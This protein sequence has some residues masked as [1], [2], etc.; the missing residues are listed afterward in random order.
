MNI[1]HS[2]SFFTLFSTFYNSSLAQIYIYN[3]PKILHST[4]FLG[5][6]ST[7]YKSNFGQ[8]YILQIDCAPPFTHFLDAKRGGALRDG[9]AF[10]ASKTWL[11]F[12]AMFLLG[13]FGC[14]LFEVSTKRQFLV[15]LRWSCWWFFY[16]YNYGVRQGIKTTKMQNL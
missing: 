9:H 5:T 15:E 10:F 7:F 16:R 4:I 13:T 8:F 11:I 2:T 6:S 14:I 1:L 3:K 12:F